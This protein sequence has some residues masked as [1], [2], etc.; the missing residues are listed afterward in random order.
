MLSL[1]AKLSRSVSE[2]IE[3]LEKFNILSFD[4]VSNL[5]DITVTLL[6]IISQYMALTIFNIFSTI[7]FVLGKKDLS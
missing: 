4:P 3:R 1:I 5:L 6:Q 2:E 7:G